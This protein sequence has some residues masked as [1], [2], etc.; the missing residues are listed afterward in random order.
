MVYNMTNMTNANNVLELYIAV[1]NSSEGQLI[2][3]LFL[4]TLFIVILIGL[5]RRNTP[6]E[7]ITAAGGVCFLVGSLLSYVG[8]MPFLYPL[9]AGIIF[10]AGAIG[11]YKQT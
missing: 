7:S 11:I 10:A 9:A 8:V 4:T 2:S 1:N 6:V 5:L 3:I